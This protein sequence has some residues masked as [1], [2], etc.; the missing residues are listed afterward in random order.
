[1]FF[2][3]FRQLSTWERLKLTRTGGQEDLVPLVAAKMHSGTVAVPK[4]TQVTYWCMHEQEHVLA[5]G[6]YLARCRLLIGTLLLRKGSLVDVHPGSWVY[7]WQVCVCANGQGKMPERNCKKTGKSMV[8]SSSFKVLLIRRMPAFIEKFPQATM[9]ILLFLDLSGSCCGSSLSHR[10]PLPTAQSDSW[11]PV[12]CWPSIT[13]L[14]RIQ[15]RH[16]WIWDWINLTTTW[17]VPV[18]TLG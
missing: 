10:W 17:T 5:F 13:P 14:S 7:G 3:G 1:M 9:A 18:Q 2:I 4:S 12:L 8:S 6:V 15:R 16:P 11:N